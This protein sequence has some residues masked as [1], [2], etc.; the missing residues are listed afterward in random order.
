[1]L[2]ETPR[3]AN[4]GSILKQASNVTQVQLAGK[5]GKILLD[6]KFSLTPP[7]TPTPDGLVLSLANPPELRQYQVVYA[8][9]LT[10][11][12]WQKLGDPLPRN[13]ALEP[14]HHE[15]NQRAPRGSIAFRER[16]SLTETSRQGWS[17]ASVEEGGQGRVGI[18][19]NELAPI[20]GVG[21]G[22]NDGQVGTNPRVGRAKVGRP[23]WS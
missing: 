16:L 14:R 10:N 5:T 8:D 22:R 21:A 17:L 3:S 4:P 1:M 9:N 18:P 20:A 6:G 23:R 19:E 11:A 12:E 15:C 7:G 2:T 13:P